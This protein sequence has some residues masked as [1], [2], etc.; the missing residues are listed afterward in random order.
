[1]SSGVRVSS[2]PSLKGETICFAE[3][4]ITSDQFDQTFR[5]GMALVERTAQYLDG[6]GRREAR[7]LGAHASVVYATESMRLTTRLLEIASWL[8]I[9][10]A[11]NSGEIGPDEARVKRRRIK[12]GTIARPAHVNGFDE[13]PGTLRHLVEASYQ[14]NDRIVQ[15]DRALEGRQPEKLSSG[16]PNPVGAQL[17]VIQ[18]AFSGP[19]RGAVRREQLC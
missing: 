11:L 15:L 17:A 12:L 18:A 1:M 9:R 14:L 13:L 5:D 2:V 7:Q 3:R 8:L 6:P 4:F 19:R 10:R 16:E